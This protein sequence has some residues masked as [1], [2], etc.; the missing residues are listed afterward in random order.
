MEFS[1]DYTR[2]VQQ[3][4]F[5]LRYPEWTKLNCKSKLKTMVMT[6]HSC[7]LPDEVLKLRA[8]HAAH[9]PADAPPHPLRYWPAT[10][11]GAEHAEQTEAPEGGVRHT[12]HVCNLGHLLCS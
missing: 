7:A 6:T 8:G 5:E 10:H 4:G 1:Q 11:D 12:S 3:H 9:P 2:V